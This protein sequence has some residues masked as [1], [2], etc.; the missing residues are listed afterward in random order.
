MRLTRAYWCH[1]DQVC[2]VP[3]TGPLD[4][5]TTTVSAQAVDWV[6][7][8]VRSLT[9]RLDRET[10]DRVWAWLGNHRG[11]EA[12]IRELR[13]GRPYAFELATPIGRWT[14]TAH[15]VF[16]LPI[17]GTGPDRD[18]ASHPPVLTSVELGIKQ[19]VTARRPVSAPQAAE[20]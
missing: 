15:P 4:D 3:T 14:W 1:I 10:F 18:A 9:P 19:P 13:R 12:A 7:E 5:I 20:V 6:R 17:I 8:S 2:E 11:A 16:V